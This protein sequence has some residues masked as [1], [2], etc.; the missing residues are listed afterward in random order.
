MQS[1]E[2]NISKT[3]SIQCKDQENDVTATAT[4]PYCTNTNNCL[5]L[6]EGNSQPQ[7]QQ[8]TCTCM[9]VEQEQPLNNATIPNTIQVPRRGRDMKQQMIQ[10]EI[11]IDAHHQYIS[12]A[13]YPSISSFIISDPFHYCRTLIS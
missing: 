13:L 3:M 4:S 10:G 2:H 9:A 7:S 8:R 12:Y 5:E 6:H 1:K 11:A